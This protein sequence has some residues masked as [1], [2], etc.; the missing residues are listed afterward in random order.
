MIKYEDV[1]ML[2][3][4]LFIDSAILLLQLIRLPSA[5]CAAICVV[6]DF[7]LR[8][9]TITVISR[10][11][12]YDEEV[13]FKSKSYKLMIVESSTL[14]VNPKAQNHYYTFLAIIL[15]IKRQ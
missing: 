10:K 9:H 4:K 13:I 1:P 14:G 7:L 5:L 8:N 6:F 15:N 2:Q 12:C 3:K 11:K